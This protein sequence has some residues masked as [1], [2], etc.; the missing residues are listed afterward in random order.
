MQ[1]QAKWT[2]ELNRAAVIAV[3]VALACYVA[4]DRLLA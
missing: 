2:L 1:S 4:V 3:I